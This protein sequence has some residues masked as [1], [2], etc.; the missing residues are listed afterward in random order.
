MNQRAQVEYYQHTTQLTNMVTPEEYS[1]L[2]QKTKRKWRFKPKSMAPLIAWGVALFILGRIILFPLGEGIVNFISK[3]HELNS[4]QMEYKNL[5]R[6][7]VSMTKNRDYMLT[8]AYILERGHEIGMVKANE[9]QMVVVNN[10]SDEEIS[11]LIA[12]RKK[13]VE[14]GD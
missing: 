2:Y 1:L 9:A 6:Q 12:Q 11:K 13:K 4:L 14:I 8:P 5:D 7:L 3:T 10:V